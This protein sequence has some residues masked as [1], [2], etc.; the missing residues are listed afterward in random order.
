MTAF[1]LEMFAIEIG[2]VKDLVLEAV[3]LEEDD[4]YAEIHL[5]DQDTA[6]SP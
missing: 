5:V 6:I 3:V 2:V 1:N 4:I